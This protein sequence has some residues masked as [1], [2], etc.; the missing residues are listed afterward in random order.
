VSLKKGVLG[1]NTDDFSFASYAVN[2]PKSS[3]VVQDTELLGGWTGATNRRWF[4]R[5]KNNYG[6]SADVCPITITA[7]FR[8]NTNGGTCEPGSRQQCDETE[9]KCMHNRHSAVADIV[10]SVDPKFVQYWHPF[11]TGDH[12]H[13]G[14][15]KHLVDKNY[16]V[17]NC[18]KEKEICLRKTGCVSTKRYQ[19]VLQNCYESGCGNF[20]NPASAL[21]AGLG[22]LLAAAAALAVNL[23]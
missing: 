1:V 9:V 20:C 3:Y 13:P 16:Q 12:E 2:G 21:R 6:S 22:S 19:L 7:S 14:N 4:L 11:K 23:F 15:H 18:L 17:C 5:L 10:N 8:S